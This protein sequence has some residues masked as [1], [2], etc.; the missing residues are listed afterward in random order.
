[1]PAIGHPSS[2]NAIFTVNSP[3]LFMNSLVPSS[4]SINQ[5]RLHFFLSE[6]SIF[7]P[8]SDRIGISG[9][10]VDNLLVITVLDLRSASVS[11]DKSSLRVTSIVPL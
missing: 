6:K 5:K 7:L 9:Y 1:M 8:S 10:S 3:F 2:I 4:G 11:G